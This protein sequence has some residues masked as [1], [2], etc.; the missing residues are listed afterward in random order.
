MR[1]PERMVTHPALTQEEGETLRTIARKLVANLAAR[2][3]LAE[4]K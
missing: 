1:V 4:R 3:D 2:H